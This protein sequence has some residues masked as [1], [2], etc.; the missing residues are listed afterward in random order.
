MT[1]KYT[2]ACKDYP[3]MEACPGQFVTATWDEIW[4]LMELHAALAH[5]ENPDEWSD[6]ERDYLKTLISSQPVNL[7]P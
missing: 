5:G 4:K 7:K 3:G 1:A 2:Y 6:E